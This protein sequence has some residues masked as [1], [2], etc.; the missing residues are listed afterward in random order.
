MNTQVAQ[1]YQWKSEKNKLLTQPGMLLY[2]RWKK[3][4]IIY[5]RLL[6]EY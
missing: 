4:A 5:S 6:K 1:N 2:G 3:C